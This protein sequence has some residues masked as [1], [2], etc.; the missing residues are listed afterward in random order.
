[1]EVLNTAKAAGEKW[2]DTIVSKWDEISQAAEDFDEMQDGQDE[3][4]EQLRD[5]FV[6]L[7]EAQVEYLE[8]Q[9]E[10]YETY[11]DQLDQL[12]EDEERETERASIASQI[13]AISGGI[14]S[15]SKS[16]MKE[17]RSQLRDIE[18]EQLEAERERQRDEF[19]KSIDETVEEI[20]D[21]IEN[22]GKTYF[23]SA[24][25]M[26]KELRAVSANNPLLASVLETTIAGMLKNTT[27]YATGGLVDYTGPA[28]VDGTKSRPEAFLNPIQ[29]NLIARLVAGLEIQGTSPSQYLSDSS[30]STVTIGNITIQTNE[31]N[32][33][34]DFG[35]AGETL[36][37]SLQ[38]AMGERGIRVNVKR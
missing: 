15:T 36:A 7:M 12:R 6:S 31:L 3:A 17:L 25:E 1:M 26:I 18:Q 22:F 11:F 10:T 27:A 30:Y 2:A 20:S 24:D 14:D 33:A 9:Q 16:K 35:K 4:I 5:G 21:Q 29:T 38:R 19:M 28:W 8:K 32:T 23:N 34:Q 13:A 37:E